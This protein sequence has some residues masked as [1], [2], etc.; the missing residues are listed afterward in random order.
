M[1]AVWNA[2]KEF[3]VRDWTMPEKIL[4]I[5]CCILAG[6]VKGLFWGHGQSCLCHTGH[7]SHKDEDCCEEE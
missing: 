6:M 2:I 3:F 4:I 7:S 1:K 5:S